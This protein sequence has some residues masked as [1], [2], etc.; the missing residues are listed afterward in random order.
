MEAAR[1]PLRQDPEPRQAPG[2]TGGLKKDAR[3]RALLGKMSP[4][5]QMQ[6]ATHEATSTGNGG[7][8]VQVDLHA[9]NTGP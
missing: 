4:I 2:L 8:M 6:R 7:H 5:E 3:P 1:L 9:R